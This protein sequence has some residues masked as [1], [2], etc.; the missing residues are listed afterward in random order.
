MLVKL[1]KNWLAAALFTAGLALR[2]LVIVSY[3]PVLFYIDT[4]RYLYNSG[5]ND[6][7]GYRLPLRAILAIGNF[8]LLAIIQHLL[9]LAMAVA[10]YLVLVRRGTHRWLAALAI[11]PVL[12]DAYQLQ[13]EQLVLPDVWF[14]ALVVAGIA[15]LL[16]GTPPARPPALKAVIAGG[17]ILGASATFRQVGEILILPALVYL[18]ALS[19]G[20]RALLTRAAALLVAFVVPILGYMAGSYLLVGHFYLSHSG[21]TTTYGRLAAA[22]NCKTLTLPPAERGL[23]P[24][25]AQQSLGPDWLEHNPRAPIKRYYTGPLSAQASALVAR[26][27]NAVVRQQPTRVLASYLADVG[28]VFALSKV[29][30]PGITPVSRWQFQTHYPYL[31]PH[32]TPA[33][34]HRATTKFGGGKPAIWQPGATALRRYQLAGGYTPGPVLALCALAGLA[35]SAAAFTARY[36]DLRPRPSPDGP[37]NPPTDPARTGAS[38]PHPAETTPHNTDPANHSTTANRTTN[39]AETDASTSQPAQSSPH[40]VDLAGHNHV[41]GPPASPAEPGANNPQPTETDSGIAD[42]AS[43]SSGGGWAAEA[44]ATTGAGW[45]EL[46]LGCLLFFACAA[47]LL[48]MSDVF[49]FSWRYQLPALVT[50]PPAA[51][52]AVAGVLRYRSSPNGNN[53]HSRQSRS[54]SKR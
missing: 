38:D 39:P 37:T 35:G 16:A 33:E 20:W 6:P 52:A 44:A 3:R 13:M 21:V 46:A 18:I 53:Q 27:N 30:L 2:V 43:H 9:G 22:A 26:F 8:D 54:A 23:C 28:K 29:S 48:L 19:G 41:T 11:A 45:R 12:L 25:K 40:D 36:R 34:V 42:P 4:V 24:T 31:S 7:V 32:A 47:G 51:A 50:L 17:L 5:G 49:E 15:V 10:I 14:E 1:R